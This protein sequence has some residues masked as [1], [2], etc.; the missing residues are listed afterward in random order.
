MSIL[1]EAA[2]I[3]DQRKRAEYG[4]PEVEFPKIA[5]LWSQILGHE[6][7]ANQ[8]CLCM[9]A[10]KLVRLSVSPTHHDS[11]VDIAGY[12]RILEKL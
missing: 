2:E 9:I 1:E 3:V 11:M 5:A 12:A 7:T 8:V 4:P 10:G 6:V